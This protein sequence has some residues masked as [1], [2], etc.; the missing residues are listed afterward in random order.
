MVKSN[1][2]KIK[3]LIFP[4]QLWRLV[5]GTELNQTVIDH[6]MTGRLENANGEWKYSDKTWTIT[7][8]EGKHN[9]DYIT[10]GHSNK[11]LGLMGGETEMGTEVILENHDQASD[12]N[13]WYKT[14]PNK[15]GW[16]R[17]V[18]LQRP[19]DVSLTSKGRKSL[20]IEGNKLRVNQ[21]YN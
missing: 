2:T 5:N 1:K 10:E 20:T 9:A 4:G 21:Q 19:Y 7:I 18:P 13:Y 11:L 15:D 8:K 14:Y 16:F 6:Q 3:I 12:T 17:I